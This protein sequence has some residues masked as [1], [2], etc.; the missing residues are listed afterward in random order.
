MTIVQ[1]S[2][3]SFAFAIQQSISNAL[4]IPVTAVI[5]VSVVANRRKLLSGVIV[6]Y[7]VNLISGRTSDSLANA[8]TTFV[9]SDNFVTNLSANSGIVVSGVGIAIISNMSPTYSPSK[10]PLI[11][12]TG[13][14]SDD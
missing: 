14:S 6:S 12:E 3:S 8:L 10:S 11:T 9:S 4:S 13:K 7:T 2:S 5:G 1:A